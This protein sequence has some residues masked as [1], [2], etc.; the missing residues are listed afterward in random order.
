[1]AQLARLGVIKFSILLSGC[2]AHQQLMVVSQSKLQRYEY[3]H[4]HWSA[5]GDAMPVVIGKNGL[6]K[7]KQEGDLR[8]PI[9]LFTLGS[10][11]GTMRAPNFKWPYVVLKSS[12]ICVDHKDSLY[13]NQ[14]I[15]KTIIKKS[16]WI[17]GEHM[18]DVQPEYALGLIIN[19]NTKNPQPGL[20]SCIF[21]HV[22]KSPTT[23]TAGCIAMS[24]SNMYTI[25]NWLDPNLH[26]YIFLSENY[27]VA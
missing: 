26:P 11:F 25:L 12:T 3:H 23:A 18:L 9:G 15:D 16:A 21:M 5:V 13:Y 24:K 27:F 14:W 17:S 20:G 4:K 1:M 22:W 10:A 8:T 7:H 19:Y 6:T 2:V